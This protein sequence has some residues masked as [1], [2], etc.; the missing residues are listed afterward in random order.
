[1]SAGPSERGPG[2]KVVEEEDSAALMLGPDFAEAKCLMTADVALILEHK[3]QM[4]VQKGVTPKSDFLKAY[5]Y[6]NTVKQFRDK[7]IVQ[8]VRSDLEKE[9]YGLKPFEVAQLGNL[10]P[11]DPQEAR[12]L[13]PSLDMP[14]RDIDNA[15]LKV[16]LDN[17]DALRQIT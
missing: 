1:M 17:L 10:C 7:E 13:V 16:I 5:Q 6:V 8:Q 3:R 4:M 14:G 12:A 2:R 9:H 15:Q 11:Q